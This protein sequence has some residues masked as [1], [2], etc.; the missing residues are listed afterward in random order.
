MFLKRRFILDLMF[1]YK[2]LY[3]L[4]IIINLKYICY[5]QLFR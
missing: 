1:V 3:L 4:F 5:L 2:I